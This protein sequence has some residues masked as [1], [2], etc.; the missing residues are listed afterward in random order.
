MTVVRY[1][2][3]GG[4][5]GIDDTLSGPE[6]VAASFAGTGLI[7][8]DPLSFP[9]HLAELEDWRQP[10]LVDLRRCSERDLIALGE[11]LPVLAPADRLLVGPD[12]HD[13]AASVLHLPPA[14]LVGDSDET[15]AERGARRAVKLRQALRREVLAPILDRELATAAGEVARPLLVVDVGADDR[16]HGSFVP[17][18]HR[19]QAVEVAEE[20]TP[21]SAAVALVAA[22]GLE[23][24]SLA[25]ARRAVQ[26]GG[27]LVCVLDEEV[28]ASARPPSTSDVLRRVAAVTGGRHVVE[29]VWGL[30]SG[31][32]APTLGGIVAV[33][34]LGG[35]A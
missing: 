35:P 26:P 20:L 10:V 6:T 1:V 29:H 19:Y 16:W 24:D 4:G 11:V 25:L 34:P 33:R 17:P 27:L 32:G 28:V 14:C 3:R 30:H 23:L 18:P 8:D 7:I 5:D 21:A 9:W 31:P 12:Q 2:G 15:D 22:T 13:W